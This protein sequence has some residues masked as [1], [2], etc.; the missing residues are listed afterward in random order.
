MH[1]KGRPFR[2]LLPSFL[3]RLRPS[4]G[5]SSRASTVSGDGTMSYAD[6]M[7]ML[8]MPASYSGRVGSTGGYY[9]SVHDESE[10]LLTVSDLDATAHRPPRRPPRL[11][12]SLYAEYANIGEGGVGER[13]EAVTP[14]N[15]PTPKAS[16]RTPRRP[17][18]EEDDERDKENPPSL[19]VARLE[20][21]RDTHRR[22]K[23]VTQVLPKFILEASVEEAVSGA[24]VRRGIR[25][26]P[27][28]RFYSLFLL[29]G[30]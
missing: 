12:E 7:S 8:S 28:N 27:V 19:K 6:T 9:D 22:M 1:R 17:L 10:S 11:S 24:G 30:R 18:W 15:S 3:Q 5:H 4:G 25:M 16:P 23:T 29:S 2:S 26:A 13:P 21:M 14:T 20:S